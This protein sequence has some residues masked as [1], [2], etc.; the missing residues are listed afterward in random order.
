MLLTGLSSFSACCS[1]LLRII[2]VNL[3]VLK[4]DFFLLMVVDVVFDGILDDL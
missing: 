4:L 1:S 2:S 3:T